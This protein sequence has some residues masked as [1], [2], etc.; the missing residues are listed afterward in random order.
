[1]DKLGH[2]LLSTRVDMVVVVVGL[3]LDSSSLDMWAC[4]LCNIV[5]GTKVV[6]VVEVLVVL[7]VLEIRVV[8]VVLGVLGARWVPVVR[9]LRR[10]RLGLVVLVV[11]GVG[12]AYNRL[13]N[14]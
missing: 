1:M 12:R 7:E 3:Q 11:V 2:R 6:V 13:V 8:L 5:L 14:I 9:R 4:T 10:Y